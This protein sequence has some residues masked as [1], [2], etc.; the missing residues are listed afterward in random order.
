MPKKRRLP[1]ARML[2][3]YRLFRSQSRRVGGFDIFTLLIA[4]LVVYRT[5]KAEKQARER[6]ENTKTIAEVI[7]G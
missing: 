1:L 4:L 6:E 3:S 2:L 7:G 5:Y